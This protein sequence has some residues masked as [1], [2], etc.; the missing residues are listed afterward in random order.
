MSSVCCVSVWCTMGSYTAMRGT[1]SPCM[2]WQ[3]IACEL[4]S[5]QN[6]MKLGVPN[7]L[8]ELDAVPPAAPKLPS[9]AGCGD[10]CTTSRAVLSL[11]VLECSQVRRTASMG[12]YRGQLACCGSKDR[13]ATLTH[14]PVTR[15]T[16]RDTGT[17]VQIELLLR[18]SEA[19][20]DA[21]L[22]TTSIS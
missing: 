5:G 4:S 20:C 17:S 13:H 19:L 12:L 8:H 22:P 9:P 2:S 7:Q 15:R 18:Q 3:S 21:M 11:V 1:P 6:R 16:S 10:A 14:S